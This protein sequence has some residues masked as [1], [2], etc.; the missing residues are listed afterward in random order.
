MSRKA[1][2][3]LILLVW[4][5]A[6]GWLAQRRTVGIHSGVI[7]RTWPVSPGAAFFGVYRGDRQVGLATLSI[8]TLVEGL[9]TDELVTLDLP[10]PTRSVRRSTLR[11]EALYSK[12]LRLLRWETNLLTED[13]RSVVQGI[14]GEDGVITIHN[15]L[16]GA[17]ETL[18]VASPAEPLLLPGAVPFLLANAENRKI[19]RILTPTVFDPATTEISS[20][21]FRVAAESTFIVPDSAEFDSTTSRWVVVHADTTPAWRL[22][23]LEGGLPSRRWVDAHGIT[24]RIERPIGL[25]QEQ[26]AF[27]VVSTNYRA[28]GGIS[29]WDTTGTVKI[30]GT[31]PV[32]TNTQ[33]NRMRIALLGADLSG[34]A[35]G[36]EGGTQ[37]R[38]A[39]TITVIRADT[40]NRG[41]QVGDSAALALWLRATPL[42]RSDDPRVQQRA[43]DIVRNAPSSARKARLLGQWVS[44]AVRI[45]HR[46][47]SQTAVRTLARRA[48]TSD[49]RLILLVAMLRAQGVPARL[50]AGLREESGRFYPNG[51][52]EYFAG[53]WIPVDPDNGTVP[54]DASRLRLLIER[55]AR[56]LDLMLLAGRT[57]LTVLDT[58]AVQP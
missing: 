8:D 11:T 28:D 20:T 54:A 41:A 16:G 14:L 33:T 27:E 23:G 13:G 2:A 9:R 44:R 10:Q 47:G 42:I 25:L 56:P 7:V 6:L 35:P 4:F 43:A 55:P 48:G 39:D 24:V 52:V 26:S 40:V 12:S 49:D 51:W 5:G 57:E 29:G 31:A 38:E 46:P 30:S 18:T 15:G 32:A 50:A 53:D 45:E 17:V 19:G 21:R 37:E 58:A 34:F 3:T 36:V 22:D 1:V